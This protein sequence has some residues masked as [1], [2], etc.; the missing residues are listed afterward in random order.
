MSLTKVSYSMIS[1][2]PVNVK[3]Y[4][5]VGDAVHDDTAAFQAAIN[6]CQ[7]NLKVLYIPPNNVSSYYKL[8][9]TLSITKPITIIGSGSRNTTLWN[10]GL[11]SGQFVINMDG[12]TFGTFDEGKIEGITIGGSGNCLQIKNV[13]QSTFK[14]IGFRNCTHG[15]VYT[16]TRCYSNY[17]EQLYSVTAVAGDTFVMSAH[18]GGGQHEFNS[19]TFSGDTGFSI[20][21]DTYTNGVCFVNCNFE[22]CVT[23]SVYCGGYVEGLTFYGCRTEH[24]TS[25]DF[26][27]NPSTGNAVYGLVISGTAFNASNSGG[28]SRVILGG[29][30]GRVRGFDISANTVSHGDHNFSASFVTLNGDGET[31]TVANNW[32]DGTTTNCS[33]TNV[34]RP[35]I[36]VYNNEANNG[37]LSPTFELK[38]T[39]WTPIDVS[40]AGLTFTN[41]NG[42]YELVGNTVYLQGSVT[43]PSTASGASAI[44]GGLPYTVFNNYAARAGASVDLTDGSVTG[45][46]FKINDT[47]I[48]LKNNFSTDTTN[49]NMSGSTIYFSGFYKVA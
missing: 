48:I 4:G 5:A 37:K 26:Q 42:Y 12:T 39:S 10:G 20:S 41:A 36:A 8:T 6:Y 35:G 40:G 33:A 2:A 31:G 30:G 9:S 34:L 49:A 14:D 25:V 32:L 38:Q 19:C 7:D 24:C 3:D 16:G 28:T 15:V 47:A 1:D 23:N 13:S 45:I 43:Y 21:T 22:S 27:I 29:A 18:T 44:I 17:F 46:I 11:S